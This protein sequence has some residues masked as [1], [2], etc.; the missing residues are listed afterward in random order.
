MNTANVNVNVD[1]IPISKKKKR[2]EVEYIKARDINSKFGN[3]RKIGK[4]QREELKKS[5]EVLGDF[6]CFIVDEKN[7]IIG[8]NQRLSIIKEMYP[9]KELL[10]KKLYGYTDAEKRA[11]NIK[12]NSHSGEWDIDLLNDWLADLTIS[13]DIIDEEKIED[14][15]IKEM[16]LI[17]FEK[18]D[19]LLIVC[20]T[21][22]DYA[23]LLE[24]VGLDGTEK[25][26]INGKKKIRARALWWNDVKD[27][28]K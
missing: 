16:E 25:A 14:R 20:S 22:L 7:S 21:E 6:G 13:L 1:N 23:R 8:G 12:A 17:P 9:E 5:L 18:Y 10:C 3:P 19:Y 2:I 4:K 26:V 24:K 11:I 15:E 27:K 28:F